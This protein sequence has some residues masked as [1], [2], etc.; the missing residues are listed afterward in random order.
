[1]AL[2]ISRQFARARELVDWAVNSGG[3]RLR[4]TSETHSTDDRTMERVVTVTG[5]AREVDGIVTV[6]DAEATLAPDVRVH[7]GDWR[8]VMKAGTE[9]PQA[10]QWLTVLRAHGDLIVGERARVIGSTQDSSGAL[11]LVYAKRQLREET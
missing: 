6:M 9:P 10:G 7:T 3:T 2:D 8:V 1:M 4:V 11:H 5:E